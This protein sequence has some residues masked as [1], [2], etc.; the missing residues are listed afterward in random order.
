MG[1][2][3]FRSV[4]RIPFWT[5]GCLILV[6]VMIVVFISVEPLRHDF[7]LVSVIIYRIILPIYQLT[8]NSMQILR[9]GCQDFGI[10]LPFS[11]FLPVDKGVFENRQHAQS[12][13]LFGIRRVI[14]APEP[15]AVR[16][17][18]GKTTPSFGL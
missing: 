2:T 7:L 8:A 13:Q 4:F 3:S 14:G 15:R 11:P 1:F 10:T 16:Y 6:A 18:N 12:L 9:S 5:W 17:R